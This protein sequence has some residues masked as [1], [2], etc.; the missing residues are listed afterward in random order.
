MAPAKWCYSHVPPPR[1]L[2]TSTHDPPSQPRRLAAHN[3]TPST[4]IKGDL[5]RLDAIPDVELDRPVRRSCNAEL[6][7]NWLR[8]GL[9]ASSFVHG[10]TQVTILGRSASNC[11]CAKGET[12]TEGRGAPGS[13]YHTFSLESSSASWVCCED[14]IGSLTHW[15][16]AARFTQPP[17]SAQSGA[18]NDCSIYKG[19]YSYDG[20]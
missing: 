14:T 3:S 11:P 8:L 18:R 9:A 12:A 20:L 2:R 19:L 6:V 7:V 5:T 4:D 13:T 1:F 17:L 10:V 16:S 15:I